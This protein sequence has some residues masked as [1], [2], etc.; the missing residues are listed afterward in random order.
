MK[1]V[2]KANRN[3]KI[4]SEEKKKKYGKAA[5][6]RILS[7]HKPLYSYSGHRDEGFAL[8]WSSKAPGINKILYN[9]KKKLNI[10]SFFLF[11]GFLASGDCKGNIH[12]WKPSESGWVVN[13]HSLGGHKESVEDL[14]WSP[15]EVNV[16]AS[17]SV[18]KS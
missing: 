7:E 16:L 4:G 14:Q 8:D 6:K 18:D 17:C 2:E 3:R 13:L 12:T 10:N 11:L 5:P 1:D 15:N 9:I